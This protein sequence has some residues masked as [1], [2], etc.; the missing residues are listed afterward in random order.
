MEDDS[1]LMYGLSCTI[2]LKDDNGELLE[3]SLFFDFETV[4]FNSGSE[5]V[6]SASVAE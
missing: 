1:D 6:S 4:L 3:C 5:G 2:S